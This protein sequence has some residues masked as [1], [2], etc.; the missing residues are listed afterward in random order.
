MPEPR[1]G[2]FAGV[3]ENTIYLPGGGARQGLG[4]TSVNSAFRVSP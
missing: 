3:I 2:I 4:A 1:H